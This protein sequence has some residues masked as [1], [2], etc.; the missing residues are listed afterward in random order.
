M[1]LVHVSIMLS[2]IKLSLYLLLTVH[3][4][5]VCSSMDQL[6][7]ILPLFQIVSRFGFSRFISLIMYLDTSV[8]L[9][10]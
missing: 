7:L 9:D 3:A 1:L 10:A 4:V 5:P 2:P 8:Y 6:D